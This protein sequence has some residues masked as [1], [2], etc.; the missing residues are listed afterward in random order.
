MGQIPFDDSVGSGIFFVLGGHSL[1]ATQVVSR[2]QQAFEI[3]LPL[4]RMF[5]TPTVA[6]LA[7]CIEAFLWSVES[8][9]ASPDL[10]DEGREEGEI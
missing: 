7:E 2:V 9:Q 3:Q 5:E 6:G 4:R 10:S 8:S 1:L